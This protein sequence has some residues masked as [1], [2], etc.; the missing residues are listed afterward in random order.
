GEKENGIPRSFV[1]DAEGRLAWMGY[2]KDL[3]T[4]LQKIVG[5]N[6]DINKALAQRDERRRLKELDEDAGYSIMY[7]PDVF[8]PGYVERPDSNLLV[9]AE[10]VRKEPKLKYARS[11]TYHTFSSLLRINQTKAYEYGREILVAA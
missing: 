10:I 8:Q 4:V 5:N 2:P 7:P 9:L 11:I 1:V 6:W 3:D